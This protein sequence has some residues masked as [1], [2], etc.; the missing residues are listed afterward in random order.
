MEVDFSMLEPRDLLTK[1]ID[2]L[3]ALAAEKRER[4]GA[5]K[6]AAA[7]AGALGGPRAAGGVW[8]LH[9]AQGGLRGVE[10]WRPGCG[11]SRGEAALTSA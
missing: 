2:E 9:T 1:D 11:G 6:A 4:V 3:R 7:A 5:D 10:G 8:H